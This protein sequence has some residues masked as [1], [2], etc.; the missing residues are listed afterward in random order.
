MTSDKEI[1]IQRRIALA[2]Q[3]CG[4]AHL[5]FLSRLLPS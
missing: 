5:I 4:Q 1:E 3:V 2:W